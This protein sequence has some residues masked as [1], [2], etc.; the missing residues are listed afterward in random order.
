MELK[1]LFRSSFIAKFNYAQ[2][3]NKWAKDYLV[4]I[5]FF[6]LGGSIALIFYQKIGYTFFYQ[7]FVPEAILWACGHDFL[8]PKQTIAELIPFLKGQALSFD[9]KTLPNLDLHNTTSE[10]AGVQPYLTWS[11]AFLWKWFGVNYRALNPLIFVLW[12]A[13]T[14]GIYLLLRQFCN[15]WV[16]I[17]AALFICFSPVMIHMIGSLRD[18]SKAPFI[19]WA[20]FLLIH[21]IKQTT[22]EGFKIYISPILA[23]AIA[24]LGMGFRSDLY[25]LLPIGTLF[26]LI[27][28]SDP[29]IKSIIRQVFSRAKIGIVFAA[30]FIIFASPILKNGGPGGVGG[31]FIMQGMSEPFRMNLKLEPASYITGWA[32]S[33]ELT[34]SSIA[35]SAREKDPEKWDKREMAGIPGISNS[36]VM[37]L[38]TSN[39]LQWAN[40]FI[41]DFA[42]QAIKSFT[43]IVGFPLYLSNSEFILAKPYSD[44]TPQGLI[45]SG[46]QRL[47]HAFI[48][49]IFLVGFLLL[50]FNS[51]LISKSQCAALIF[52]FIFLGM[53]PGIQFHFRHFFYL[54]FIWILLF[55]F[56]LSQLN[57]IWNHKRIFFKF[58]LSITFLVII[59]SLAY[60]YIERYQRISLAAELH[61]SFSHPRNAIT[62]QKSYTKDGNIVISVPV[63]SE[64]LQ[65]IQGPSDSM[66]PAIEF[67]GSQWDVR[68]AAAR[69][70]LTISGLDCK[71]EDAVI[72]FNYKHSN[73]T[74]QPLDNKYVS[75][76]K[77]PNIE[78]TILFSGFYRPT[79][80]FESITIPANLK[81]CEVKLERISDTSKLPYA[82]TT[83]INIRD[84]TISNIKSLGNYTK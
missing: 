56:S 34:L 78:R 73:Y 8:F 44:K 63:P 45:Y 15:K 54:E 24:G 14:A 70:L 28:F 68:S 62:I 32:Y 84:I 17:L 3:A 12:G 67:V 74:W 38:G 18:F 37:Y 59:S 5:F 2:Y 79:Q 55:I 42:T 76:F 7:N 27:G 11:V 80:Y 25:F 51:Y 81:D 19:I 39:L 49:A 72:S 36:Q 10:F 26:L 4:A 43:W 31:V 30:A 64:Y 35:A 52:L 50:L 29:K 33:D 66:T 13:Y 23:G 9:C 6:V 41:G 1:S 16:A 82:F 71:K 22:K 60:F 46:Y 40:L 20:L 61:S 53:Y 75:K 58:S 48:L 21:T 57:S 69:Y 83:D 77:R 65:L 47:S